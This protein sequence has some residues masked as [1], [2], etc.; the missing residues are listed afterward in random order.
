MA[1]ADPYV[2]PDTNVLRNRF[3]IRDP[4]ALTALEADLTTIRITE[5]ALRPLR[6]DYDLNHLQTFH[7]RIFGD[8]YPWAG[9]LRT[10]PIAKSEM[11]ALPEHVEVYLTAVFANLAQERF[12]RE[13]TRPDLVQRLTHYLAEINAVHPFREGNGRTQRAFIRQ[14]AADAGYRIAWERANPARNLEASIASMRGD[15]NPLTAM[16]DDLIDAI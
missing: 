13:L 8:L 1:V 15:N 2:Y 6:G 14:L 4:R 3:D 12:L 10:V 11:F 7:R 9:E 5:L 16:L